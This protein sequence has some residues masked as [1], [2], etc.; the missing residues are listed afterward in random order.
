MQKRLEIERI[1]TPSNSAQIVKIDD[2]QTIQNKTLMHLIASNANVN[3]NDEN[4]EFLFNENEPRGSVD[5]I[6][7]YVNNTSNGTSNL[8]IIKL[9]TPTQNDRRQSIRQIEA[10]REVILRIMQI[11]THLLNSYIIKM[12]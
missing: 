8:P 3:A 9:E 10:Q 5:L 2:G 4:G 11:S 6:A 12:K 7:N 1:L